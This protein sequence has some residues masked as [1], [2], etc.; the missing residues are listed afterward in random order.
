MKEN[1]L[2]ENRLLRLVLGL[3]PALVAAT[4][5]MNAIYLGVIAIVVLLVASILFAALGRN[6]SWKIKVPVLLTIVAAL[7]TVM[8]LTFM[9]ILPEWVMALHRYLPLSVAGIVLLMR[10]F[11]PEEIPGRGNAIGDSLIMGLFFALALLVLGILRELFGN[12]TV[13]GAQIFAKG[14]SPIL[15]FALVP[16]AFILSGILLAIFRRLTAKTHERQAG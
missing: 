4:S 6:T 12:G 3:C 2:F 9:A 1:G 14:Y 8:Q 10:P 13:F 16:G 11:W 7:V 15:A 5:A